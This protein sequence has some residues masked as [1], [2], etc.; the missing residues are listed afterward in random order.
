MAIP[1]KV[2]PPVKG[3]ALVQA[4]RNK[5]GFFVNQKK[6]DYRKYLESETPS[7]AP[8]DHTHHHTHN[9]DSSDSE[10]PYNSKEFIPKEGNLKRMQVIKGGQHN[11]PARYLKKRGDGQT[12][13][14]PNG[15]HSNLKRSFRYRKISLRTEF[16]KP[17]FASTREESESEDEGDT[18]SMYQG[19][20]AVP[21]P[22]M[23]GGFPQ[24]SQQPVNGLSPSSEDVGDDGDN[25]DGEPEF[26]KV[27]IVPRHFSTNKPNSQLN[28]T[29][30]V[31]SM[32]GHS[33]ANAYSKITVAGP[34]RT[35]SSSSDFGK[36]PALPMR[37]SSQSDIF[38]LNRKR[39]NSLS[40]HKESHATSPG[41][42]FHGGALDR[43]FEESLSTLDAL[44][45]PPPLVGS[46]ADQYGS[47]NSLDNILVEPPE[48]FSITDSPGFEISPTPHKRKLSRTRKV[49]SGSKIDPVPDFGTGMKVDESSVPK[50]SHRKNHSNGKGV[51]T[52]PAP[53]RDST[54]SSDTGYTSSTTSP[55]YN[56][57]QQNSNRGE[58]KAKIP[59]I[60][61]GGVYFEEEEEE[62]TRGEL[63][64][65]PKLTRFPSH[66]EAGK[67]ASD[68]LGYGLG[69]MRK[70]PSQM[71]LN[72][73]QSRCYVPLVFHSSRL[74]GAGVH[75]DPNLFSVQV[76]LV[77][78]SEELIKVRPKW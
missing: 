15:F 24:S 53:D 2:P 19:S 71:S 58:G 44:D 29:S 30:S 61:Q 69:G 63:P 74:E 68:S 41:D 36:R 38:K 33:P 3:G 5:D 62:V 16:E 25:D 13:L 59:S 47:Q 42:A 20:S 7:S 55:G 9:E 35:S 48:M 28:N 51:T 60:H 73:D 72:S 75:H 27:I 65:T 67:G 4:S 78:N 43:G 46:S 11:P 49:N 56:T 45:L 64:A 50:S 1:N 34:R 26:N 37:S 77:E 52:L 57:E 76:C 14:T 70:I 54:E 6:K 66:H 10:N 12:G 40:S 23:G 32:A 8:E 22:Q 39:S 17:L 18:N 21:G 31:I